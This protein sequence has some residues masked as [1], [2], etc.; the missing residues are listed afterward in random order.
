MADYNRAWQHLTAYCSMISTAVQSPVQLFSFLRVP[1]DQVLASPAMLCL[2]LLQVI[3][4]EPGNISPRLA[5]MRA[6]MGT[7]ANDISVLQTFDGPA[8]E[9]INGEGSRRVA[10]G[11]KDMRHCAENLACCSNVLP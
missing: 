3:T 7:A 4:K 6:D 1:D 10:S 11:S 9:T 2:P 8:P 5:E